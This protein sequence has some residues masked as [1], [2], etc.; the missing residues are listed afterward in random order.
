MYQKIQPKTK[1]KP[2]TVQNKQIQPEQPNRTN[3]NMQ[4]RKQTIMRKT[5]TER[6][7]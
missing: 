6:Q 2:L 7:N 5:K 1:P 4:I 3:K